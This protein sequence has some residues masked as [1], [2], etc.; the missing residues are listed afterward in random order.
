MT[1]AKDAQRHWAGKEKEY[2]DGIGNPAKVHAIRPATC[3]E[4]KVATF[5]SKHAAKKITHEPVR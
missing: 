1:L 3:T 2:I 4:G 5:H